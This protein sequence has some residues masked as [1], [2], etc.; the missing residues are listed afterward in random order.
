MPNKRMNAIKDKERYEALREQ[1]MSKEK[2]ARIAN[3]DRTEA[4]KRGGKAKKYEDRTKKELYDKAKDIGL[5]VT[6]DMKKDQII[7][8]LRNH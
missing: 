8:K 6:S 7:K 3:T 2:A 5:E 1:G 4:G